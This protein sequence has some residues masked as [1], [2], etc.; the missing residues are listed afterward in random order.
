MYQQYKDKAQ[1]FLIYIREAHPN[2]GWQV[3]QNLQD[4]WVVNE[5]KTWEERRKLAQDFLDRVKLS[6]PTLI[7]NMDNKADSDYKAW[8]DRVYVVGIDGKIIFKGGEGPKGFKPLE[9]ATVFETMTNVK[10]LIR[11]IFFW[12]KLKGDL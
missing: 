1:F 2:D 8:P 6:L 10:P 5:P 11:A 3:P 7:D 4:G 12:G 9:I